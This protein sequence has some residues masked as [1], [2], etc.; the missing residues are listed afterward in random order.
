MNTPITVAAERALTLTRVFDAPRELVW[1][2]WTDQRH[3]AQWWGPRHHPNT[4]V[5]IDARVGGRWRICLKG[6]ADGRELWHGG[7]FREV[8]KKRAPRFHLQ[9][10]RR[11]RAWRGEHRHHHVR[12]AGRQNDHDI[13]ARAVRLGR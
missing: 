1:Q 3:A 8:V 5:E 4:H 12:R 10:G 11:R 9:V 6:V 2:A 13:S 7:V